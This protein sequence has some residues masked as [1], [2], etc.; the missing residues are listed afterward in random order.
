MSGF[1]SIFSSDGKEK[2]VEKL[3]TS[4]SLQEALAAISTFKDPRSLSKHLASKLAGAKNS[5]HSSLS[6]TIIALPFL[7]RLQHDDSK[8]RA[9][10]I[11]LSIAEALRVVGCSAVATKNG[12]QWPSKTT[13]AN[14][15]EYGRAV[16][17]AGLE[18]K[19]HLT[20]A[21]MNEIGAPVWH[22]LIWASVVGMVLLESVGGHALEVMQLAAVGIRCTSWQKYGAVWLVFSVFLANRF[23]GPDADCLVR[24]IIKISIDALPR[25]VWVEARVDLLMMMGTISPGEVCGLVAAHDSNTKEITQMID[26]IIAPAMLSTN[27]EGMF[28]SNREHAHSRNKKSESEFFLNHLWGKLWKQICRF[29][30]GKKGGEILW[31]IAES[32]PT[33]LGEVGM[34]VA[35][36]V[37][38]TDS[39]TQYR[40]QNIPENTA[41]EYAAVLLDPLFAPLFSS[42]GLLGELFVR[43]IFHKG[44]PHGFRTFMNLLNSEKAK[45]ALSQNREFVRLLD[46]QIPPFVGRVRIADCPVPLAVGQTAVCSQLTEQARLRILR[47][48]IG[49]MAAADALALLKQHACWGEISVGLDDQLFPIT[50]ISHHLSPADFTSLWSTLRGM[51]LGDVEVRLSDVSDSFESSARFCGWL[52]GTRHCFRQKAFRQHFIAEG[53]HR[54]LYESIAEATDALQQRSVSPVAV[55][56]A[57]KCA[58]ICDAFLAAATSATPQGDFTDLVGCLSLL[59]EVL[60]SPAPAEHSGMRQWCQVANPFP[61]CAKVHAFESDFNSLLITSQCNLRVAGAADKV[62]RLPKWMTTHPVDSLKNEIANL[63][64]KASQLMA[65][66]KINRD[67]LKALQRYADD[68]ANAHKHTCGALE[69]G[70]VLC[71]WLS[72]L[73][74]NVLLYAQDQSNDVVRKTFRN[75]EDA[76]RKCTPKG[77]E[78]STLSGAAALLQA[79][80]RLQELLFAQMPPLAAQDRS[81]RFDFDHTL[82]GESSGSPFSAVAYG[83]LVDAIVGAKGDGK[84]IAVDEALGKV[85]GDAFPRFL[86]GGVVGEFSEFTL[87][88]LDA[89]RETD[90]LKAYCQRIRNTDSLPPTVIR[91]L[92]ATHLITL[93]RCARTMLSDC[94]GGKFYREEEWMS[95]AVNDVLS[96]CT[97]ETLAFWRVI[98]EIPFSPS[99]I[100]DLLT[101]MTPPVKN[102]GAATA[103]EIEKIVGTFEKWLGSVIA[104][105]RGVVGDASASYEVL[106]SFSYFAPLMVALVFTANN[107]NFSLD[108]RLEF[109]F[110]F[111]KIGDATRSDVVQMARSHIGDVVRIV[112]T[113]GS[114]SATGSIS[115]HLN[116]IKGDTRACL[117]ICVCPQASQFATS[118]KQVASDVPDAVTIASAVSAPLTAQGVSIRLFAHAPNAMELYAD[119]NLGTFEEEIPL[120][121]EERAKRFSFSMRL[122]RDLAHKAEIAQWH[123]LRQ[124]SLPLPESQIGLLRSLPLRD[125]DGEGAFYLAA[126]RLNDAADEQINLQDPLVGKL[127]N[128]SEKVAARLAGEEWLLM[129][130]RPIANNLLHAH[131]HGIPSDPNTIAAAKSFV[132]SLGVDVADADSGGEEIGFAELKE[133]VKACD[134]LQTLRVKK[135]KALQISVLQYK[136]SLRSSSSGH[137]VANEPLDFGAALR[138]AMSRYDNWSPRCFELFFCSP[139]T[140]AADLNRLVD[141]MKAFPGAHFTIVAIEALS[142]DLLPDLL[143]KIRELGEGAP[144]ILILSTIDANTLRSDLPKAT[145]SSKTVPMLDPAHYKSEASVFI[146]GPSRCGRSFYARKKYGV[147]DCLPHTGDGIDLAMAMAFFREPRETPMTVWIDINSYMT[148]PSPKDRQK[149]V[150]LNH[151]LLMLVHFRVLFDDVKGVIVPIPEST[152]FVIEVP[153]DAA[154]LD[155]SSCSHFGPV[156]TPSKR[157]ADFDFCDR[158]SKVASVLNF[159]LMPEGER[160]VLLTGSNGCMSLWEAHPDPV[161]V[162]HLAM[163]KSLIPRAFASRLEPDQ[164]A[165]ELASMG[166]FAMLFQLLYSRFAAL[167]EDPSCAIS[168][169]AL[170]EPQTLITRLRSVVSEVCGRV[171]EEKTP[172]VTWDTLL[173]RSN[174]LLPKSILCALCKDLANPDPQYAI[175]FDSLRQDVELARK[176]GA[177]KENK[178]RATSHSKRAMSLALALKEASLQDALLCMILN[179]SCAPEDLEDMYEAFDALDFVNVEEMLARALFCVERQQARLPLIIEGNTGVGKSFILSI[180]FRVQ[181]QYA[182]RKAR[183]LVHEFLLNMI[184]KSL[185]GNARTALEE[186]T[187]CNGWVSD[188][189]GLLKEALDHLSQILERRDFAVTFY[190]EFEKLQEGLEAYPVLKGTKLPTCM[191]SSP[192]S[193]TDR[194]SILDFF[195]SLVKNIIPTEY[196]IVCH[197]DTSRADIIHL[198]EEPFELADAF[199]E[200]PDE[201]VND[202]VVPVVYDECNTM[203]ETAGLI[204]TIMSDRR[205]PFYR[206]AGGFS[207]DF[208]V[209]FVGAI[210]RK[211]KDYATQELHSSLDRHVARFEVIKG[212]CQRR[213]YVGAIMRRCG[214]YI[215]QLADGG[216]SDKSSPS[217]WV[218]SFETIKDA[219]AGVV[220]AVHSRTEELSRRENAASPDSSDV[221]S[222][223]EVKKVHVVSQREFHKLEAVIRT[224]CFLL[225]QVDQVSEGSKTPASSS[226]SI[227]M[228][229]VVA[230]HYVYIARV[231][232]PLV[233]GQLRNV[234]V[235]QC[236]SEGLLCEWNPSPRALILDAIV[237]TSTFQLEKGVALTETLKENIFLT[238]L[239]CCSHNKHK[240][241]LAIIGDSGMGKTLANRVVERNLRGECS[242]T[243]FCQRLPHARFFY[244]QGASTTTSG[245]VSLVCERAQKDQERDAKSRSVVSF[246]E[247]SLP[248]KEARVQKSLHEPVD[249]RVISI[250]V[251]SNKPFDDEANQNRF[252]VVWNETLEKDEVLLLTAGCL[253]TSCD[254]DSPPYRCVGL[255]DTY[256][257]LRNS[258]DHKSLQMRDYIYLLK[259]LAEVS[260]TGLFAPSH[261]RDAI[262]LN[263]G[264]HKPDALADV[265]RIYFKNVHSAQQAQ[266]N[267]DDDNWEVSEE[268][269]PVEKILERSYSRY[270]VRGPQVRPRFKLLIDPSTTYDASV[271]AVDLVEDVAKRVNPEQKTVYITVENV[272]EDLRRMYETRILGELRVSMERGDHVFIRNPETL[273]SYLFDVLN[274]NYTRYTNPEGRQIDRAIVAVGAA[275]HL[276]EVHPAFL[277]TF[278][279]NA[280]TIE[281]MAKSNVPFL[282]RCEKYL[283]RIDL[284]EA[285]C[286]PVASLVGNY[287]HECNMSMFERKVTIASAVESTRRR[288]TPK[289]AAMEPDHVFRANCKI[290]SLVTPARFL[291]MCPQLVR[292]VDY[293]RAYLNQHHFS[294]DEIASSASDASCTFVTVRDEPSLKRLH[295]SSDRKAGD[296]FDSD[297]YATIDALIDDLKRE[298]GRGCIRITLSTRSRLQNPDY[299]WALR[300]RVRLFATLVRRPVVVAALHP[301]AVTANFSVD[302]NFVHLDSCSAP[303]ISMLL[304]NSYAGTS[305]SVSASSP[306]FGQLTG[307]TISGIL[308]DV[309]VD[310]VHTYQPIPRTPYANA[311]DARGQLAKCVDMELFNGLLIKR[312]SVGLA[313]SSVD[314]LITEAIEES[315]SRSA[316]FMAILNKKSLALFAHAA[317]PILK[318]I[319]DSALIDD[320]C[321]RTVG[322]SGLQLI[323]GRYRQYCASQNPLAAGRGEDTGPYELSGFSVRGPYRHPY[324]SWLVPVAWHASNVALRNRTDSTAINACPFSLFRDAHSVFSDIDFQECSAAVNADVSVTKN[325]LLDALLQ[326]GVIGNVSGIGIEEEQRGGFEAALLSALR[327]F[328][329][330]QFAKMGDELGSTDLHTKVPAYLS[331]PSCERTL[332]LICLISSPKMSML[333]RS[334]MTEVFLSLLG[335]QNEAGGGKHLAN[336]IPSIAAATLASNTPSDVATTHGGLSLLFSFLYR[337]RSFA[338]KEAGESIS[339]SGCLSI[340]SLLTDM[341]NTL[342]DDDSEAALRSTIYEVVNTKKTVRAKGILRNASDSFAAIDAT[343]NGGRS[344]RVAQMSIAALTWYLASYVKVGMEHGEKPMD[345]EKAK[346]VLKSIRDDLSGW[347]GD[348][349]AATQSQRPLFWSVVEILLKAYADIALALYRHSLSHKSSIVD[350]TAFQ[351][352]VR[353]CSDLVAAT[354]SF[355]ECGGCAADRTTLMNQ[356]SNDGPT[357][358]LNI[359]FQNVL[360]HHLVIIFTRAMSERNIVEALNTVNRELSVCSGVLIDTALWLA[361][362]YGCSRSPNESVDA[363]TTLSNMRNLPYVVSGLGDNGKLPGDFD[364]YPFDILLASMQRK[365]SAARMLAVVEGAAAKKVPYFC[366]LDV[367]DENSVRLSTT[368]FGLPPSISEH[369]LFRS[370]RDGPL[371]CN[372][373][374]I[375]QRA[376]L[377]HAVRV[378]VFLTQIADPQHSEKQRRLYSALYDRACASGHWHAQSLRAFKF[379]LDPIDDAFKSICTRIASASTEEALNMLRPDPSNMLL[380]TVYSFVMVEIVSRMTSNSPQNFW[381]ALLL[382]PR[383]LK[384]KTVFGDLFGGAYLIHGFD[385]G[386]KY[387]PDGKRECNPCSSIPSLDHQYTLFAL[388]Y[389]AIL[390]YCILEPTQANDL[391][392]HVMTNHIVDGLVPGG[393]GMPVL[394]TAGGSCARHLL[395]LQMSREFSEQACGI[396]LMT[397]FVE[398]LKRPPPA[399]YGTIDEQYAGHV[400]F[401]ASVVAKESTNAVVQLLNKEISG[402]QWRKRVSAIEKFPGWDYPVVALADGR[403]IAEATKLAQMSRGILESFAGAFSASKATT[404]IANLYDALNASAALIPKDSVASI[405]DVT[406]SKLKILKGQTGVRALANGIAAYNVLTD[407]NNGRLA[408]ECGAEEVGHINETDSVYA[409]VTKSTEDVPDENDAG[410]DGL[411]LHALSTIGRMVPLT[412]TMDTVTG[413]GSAGCDAWR[414]AIGARVTRLCKESIVSQCALLWAITSARHQTA[415]WNSDYKDAAYAVL[416][417]FSED[418]AVTSNTHTAQR[419]VTAI[420]VFFVIPALQVKL[421]K[422]S[423]AEPFRLPKSRAGNETAAAAADL[424]A[425]RAKAFDAR[426]LHRVA[427]SRED[428]AGVC[429]SLGAH[430]STDPSSFNRFQQFALTLLSAEDGGRVDGDT[431]PLA[432]A[433]RDRA[434]AHGKAWLEFFP[435]QHNELKVG[436]IAE[437]VLGVLESMGDL[438]FATAKATIPHAEYHAALREEEAERLSAHIL[439]EFVAGQIGTETLAEFCDT[440][441]DL[442]NEYSTDAQ[443]P[444]AQS[445]SELSGDE[446]LSI[447]PEELQVTMAHA[448][449]VVSVVNKCLQDDIPRAALSNASKAM[450]AMDCA[451]AEA[452]APLQAAAPEPALVEP[453]SDD[454]YDDD[455]MEDF[456]DRLE[457]AGGVGS[458]SLVALRPLVPAY[459]KR[460]AGALALN[461]HCYAHT[462]AFCERLMAPGQEAPAKGPVGTLTI[463]YIEP[464][465]ESWDVS[466][467]PAVSSVQRYAESL[468]GTFVISSVAV[469]QAGTKE[470]PADIDE[471]FVDP[472]R[473]VVDRLG[474]IVK[475][476]QARAMGVVYSLFIGPAD[477]P[478]LSLLQCSLSLQM[479]GEEK[480]VGFPICGLATLSDAIAIYSSKMPGKNFVPDALHSPSLSVAALS[481]S[482]SPL[483]AISPCKARLVLRCEPIDSVVVRKRRYDGAGGL[484]QDERWAAAPSDAV[485]QGLSAAHLQASHTAT[486]LGDRQQNPTTFSAFSSDNFAILTSRMGRCLLICSPVAILKTS[487]HFRVN[488]FMVS[489]AKTPGQPCASIDANAICVTVASETPQLSLASLEERVCGSAKLPRSGLIFVCA[490]TGL[491]IDSGDVRFTKQL[492]AYAPR[493]LEASSLLGN[494]TTRVTV[495]LPTESLSFE[496]ST[497]TRMDVVGE[498][499]SR[500]HD[501]ISQ[502]LWQGVDVLEP[503]FGGLRLGHL[504]AAEGKWIPSPMSVALA[505][506]AWENSATS[507]ECVLFSTPQFTSLGKTLE[508]TFDATPVCDEQFVDVDF[509]FPSLSSDQPEEVKSLRV[510]LGGSNPII[511]SLR[512]TCLTSL[513]ALNTSLPP[514]LLSGAVSFQGSDYS[515]GMIVVTLSRNAYGNEYVQAQLLPSAAASITFA[516]KPE[517]SIP[518]FS[519]AP[520]GAN[521]SDGEDAITDLRAAMDESIQNSHA[522]AVRDFAVF[523][524]AMSAGASLLRRPEAAWVERL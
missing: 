178:I 440:I 119:A 473:V 427:L 416:E 467:A 324:S 414:E 236:N 455:S 494:F 192:P 385:C 453:A 295:N 420:I 146:H 29:A 254:A 246:D 291:Q 355:L 251:L 27:C 345:P 30:Y 190:S 293:T 511:D 79:T 288:N 447:I 500:R 319:A 412:G 25:E 155:V 350:E 380:P 439:G 338:D 275:T 519:F 170:E 363:V 348:G 54:R 138:I 422:D 2:S 7:A 18:T 347:V 46:E 154:A 63:E 93:R 198:L 513:I 456:E 60:R 263:C 162:T 51:N 373:Q 303:S 459:R 307:R 95:D 105:L 496:F 405:I 349:P 413:W 488:V 283:L 271:N 126:I 315:L 41:A 297:R 518:F 250:I 139:Q 475:A 344:G 522:G 517:D 301:C 458:T 32:R 418:Q 91:R 284:D 425:L 121:S 164:A 423:I 85:F 111:T 302:W 166:Q 322:L 375:G 107:S 175:F 125:G 57:V 133:A 211:S 437:V 84:I 187:D 512:D 304:L 10:L 173:S 68:I 311:F 466:S 386:A 396:H 185:G 491:V 457:N 404:P 310:F 421:S 312:F 45:N 516:S 520:I 214:K 230:I 292:R 337:S 14:F 182:I 506:I 245:Q 43:R 370:I 468:I 23:I 115:A 367:S 58:I 489:A 142:R 274:L 352:L 399:S 174:T 127:L 123:G 502:L 390:A 78:A 298:P 243:K 160:V 481:L 262:E 471:H 470:N 143:R 145:E 327:T 19:L 379:L 217:A 464:R 465:G 193:F 445:A 377:L 317:F 179:G 165:T 384:G 65:L 48:D 484:I 360:L 201:R 504:A 359:G 368:L 410:R 515:A 286:A 98:A 197:P 407:L 432:H 96:R 501:A 290:L 259:Y 136:D 22:W 282:S 326:T 113:E 140:S 35:I 400:A 28:P 417:K 403:A 335:G 39:L 228:V 280:K 474:R 24:S 219:L 268:S 204:K 81:C 101:K 132:A 37:L 194:L 485:L 104:H 325:I 88:C 394:R 1:F 205:I 249:R 333:R 181:I 47:A 188:S 279:F 229:C 278:V 306:I 120:V 382:N 287:I 308:D 391:R 510:L 264:T 61:H 294:L 66:T 331:T 242:V 44:T 227:S 75:V 281:Q 300:H 336:A 86:E 168:V 472:L 435:R 503:H 157:L 401:A 346:P 398:S 15:F 176:R 454:E 383:G 215:D 238:L 92:Q 69:R 76:W 436:H 257:E 234:L 189:G 461:V 191:T 314:A 487:F 499:I 431:I 289:N 443:R 152:R 313:P 109:F 52:Q 16:E 507:E 429:Q 34:P 135:L 200:S 203:I 108:S 232:D 495:A 83:F 233:R 253:G 118:D 451:T 80:D 8:K 235:E 258:P 415:H 389:A 158:Y 171:D 521:N 365:T 208:R 430:F 62:S 353:A 444:L 223:T 195:D 332:T 156:E 409:Y 339:S 149:H 255:R 13:V 406:F 99:L 74:D 393:G 492:F 480:S 434:K 490:A 261:L 180:I 36:G 212:D 387:G 378:E 49:R 100:D 169:L 87:Q 452:V 277:I 116:L 267:A 148:K 356:Y 341:E 342:C 186:L 218:G 161:A 221:T 94:L 358:S 441:A 296:P 5:P 20:N 12:M 309:L 433:I 483:A 446:M 305:A 207:S 4:G 71:D 244:I 273:L 50:P 402:A 3:L 376:L 213:T 272:S 226:I 460:M 357:A 141:T 177:D 67:A 82:L 469:V 231:R 318:M 419:L 122:A 210:N 150:R 438:H 128:F 9:E 97:S 53:E 239:A 361:A 112:E 330:R 343:R 371:S 184:E 89:A 216:A 206:R 372:V 40:M 102:N 240:I 90:V 117:A 479:A 77:T 106:V 524:A 247:A 328:E 73:K 137:D 299:I 55:A 172:T 316:P 462:V 64:K 163:L 334:F 167:F 285:Y 202:I 463:V 351:C 476:S 222:H 56:N 256:F 424:S 110:Q 153:S 224:I 266:L 199:S 270:D 321:R 114:S 426:K 103:D 183:G 124:G 129:F 147:T 362:C 374:D 478:I 130:P 159:L 364:H 260:S 395:F 514:R 320:K 144:R 508:L 276:F 388:L 369:N 381:E 26:Q 366:Q 450:Y 209:W 11:R 59:V 498:V 21:I 509:K 340:L 428:L 411:L 265:M 241:S 408:V 225:R 6:A 477:A 448:A 237:N 17:L 72:R 442:C 486:S 31:A 196:K 151:I 220:I 70:S 323:E 354:S 252:L 505:N 392:E 523:S 131:L 33:F 134:A 329:A 449:F 248:E 38:F 269:V 482:Q 493:T 42:G 397:S 497:D